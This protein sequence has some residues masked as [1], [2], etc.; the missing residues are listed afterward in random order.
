MKR[1]KKPMS[2]IF[3]I[4]SIGAVI[5]VLIYINQTQQENKL[6]ESSMKKL[7]EVEKL[8]EL[9]LDNE[10][11]QTPRE[12][13]KLHGD[14]TR[15]IYS[16]IE[17]DEIKNLAIKIREL[18]DEEFLAVST[19]EQYLTELYTDL[20]IWSQLNRRIEYNLVVNEKD[21]E[22]YELEGRSYATAYVSFTITEK[23][24]TLE[25]RKYI[26]RKDNDDRW[27]ILGWEYLP[28]SQD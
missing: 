23:K 8:L 21:E 3:T 27:K 24:Q 26:M 25:L 2:A 11:P 18:Y 10:Y 7:T 14:M 12:V 28:N 4:I 1:V 5:L 6:K 16:G 15:L 13:A 19:Q 20:A 22:L 9:D 17:D